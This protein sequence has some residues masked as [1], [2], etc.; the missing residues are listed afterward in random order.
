VRIIDYDLNTL[1]QFG[2]IAPAPG[3]H[4]CRPARYT[5]TETGN[6]TVDPLQRALTAARIR[7]ILALQ[8]QA[9]LLKD[10]LLARSNSLS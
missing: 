7:K 8:A 3:C 2:W 4:S 1:L 10:A 6:A 9:D 5:V